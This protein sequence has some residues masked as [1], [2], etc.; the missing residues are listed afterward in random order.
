[1]SFNFPYMLLNNVCFEKY[2]L[3]LF[4][5]CLFYG[6]QLIQLTLSSNTFRFFEMFLRFLKVV[7]QYWL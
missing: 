1:M 2:K 7:K 5:F 6:S 4:G 3:I